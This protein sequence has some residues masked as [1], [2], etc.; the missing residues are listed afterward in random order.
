MAGSDLLSGQAI[1]PGAPECGGRFSTLCHSAGAFRPI[2]QI[3][4]EPDPARKKAPRERC[5]KMMKGNLNLEPLPPRNPIFAALC[6]FVANPTTPFSVGHMRSF[7][8]GLAV[9]AGLL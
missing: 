8:I 4:E 3:G 7:A 5:G 6:L 1:V 2:S 9:R